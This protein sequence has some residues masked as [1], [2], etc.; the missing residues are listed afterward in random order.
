M[1]LLIRTFLLC[2]T[3]PHVREWL[4]GRTITASHAARELN[5]RTGGGG[6][7]TVHGAPAATIIPFTTTS[8][9]WTFTGINTLVAHP[10]RLVW[11]TFTAWDTLQAAD[12]VGVTA[13]FSTFTTT[14]NIHLASRAAIILSNTFTIV[15]EG[16]IS[17]TCATW[18]TVTCTDQI[19]IF[20][21]SVT[22]TGTVLV[23]ATSFTYGTLYSSNTPSLVPN[24]F[25]CWT[26]A[27]RY[28][29]SRTCNRARITGDVTTHTGNPFLSSRATFLF[30][31]WASFNTGN[32][33]QNS[34]ST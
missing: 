16:L 33:W 7:P 4:A 27:S 11:W 28:A 18:N 15:K 30:W 8:A 19:W 14:L 24:W 17:R 29:D 5:I 2:D 22:S 6:I 34:Q 13:S 23:D 9:D 10:N 26:F 25:V 12:R 1:L 3:I 20:T 31:F 32:Y 21:T